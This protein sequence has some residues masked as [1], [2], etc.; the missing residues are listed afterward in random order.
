VLSNFGSQGVDPIPFFIEWASGSVHPSQDSP[1]GCQLQ[2]FEVQHPDPAGVIE[3]LKNLG[4][5]MKAKQAKDA[6]L[7]VTLKTPKGIVEWS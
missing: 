7:V 2:S 4:I 5:D 1:G 3:T 6:R